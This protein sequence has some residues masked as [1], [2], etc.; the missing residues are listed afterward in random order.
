MNSSTNLLTRNSSSS[1]FFFNR[2]TSSAV[3]TNGDTDEL[4]V[5]DIPLLKL[6]DTLPPAGGTKSGFLF[7]G[8]F[9][10]MCIFFHLFYGFLCY[11]FGFLFSLFLFFN[12]RLFDLAG[13]RMFFEV[14]VSGEILSIEDNTGSNTSV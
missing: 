5:T 4:A 6:P 10:G 12:P 14:L 7:R 2:S 11:F 3:E 13:F 9:L 1:T 8:G